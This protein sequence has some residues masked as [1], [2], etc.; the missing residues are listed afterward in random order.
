MAD[1][2]FVNATS[3]G[4]SAADRDTLLIV[5]TVTVAVATVALVCVVR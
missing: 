4:T 5:A 2:P 1:L 3:E